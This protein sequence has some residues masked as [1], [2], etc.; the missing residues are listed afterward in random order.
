[1]LPEAMF[2]RWDMASAGT[3]FGEVITQTL[4]HAAKTLG[5]TA[6]SIVG[7][8]LYVCTQPWRRGICMAM[9]AM[10]PLMEQRSEQKF[11]MCAWCK[12]NNGGL[13]ASGSRPYRVMQLYLQVCVGGG[14]ITFMR[15]SPL[16][17]MLA[18]PSSPWG[19]GD[20]LPSNST[21]PVAAPKKEDDK[22]RVHFSFSDEDSERLW[23]HA[24]SL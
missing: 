1:M 15:T 20:A 11:F 13:P 6:V 12:K 19:R 7:R 18:A 10:S 16:R 5:L 21:L 14:A 24:S 2:L 23:L 8:P 9:A 22:T 3:L 4:S 17:I